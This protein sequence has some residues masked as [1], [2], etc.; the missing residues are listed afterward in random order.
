MASKYISWP[1]WWNLPLATLHR[2]TVLPSSFD[3]MAVFVGVKELGHLFRGW[4]REGC[5]V[6]IFN[7][8]LLWRKFVFT[9]VTLWSRTDTW[10]GSPSSFPQPAQGEGFFFR[11]EPLWSR[12]PVTH[13]WW[14][15]PEFCLL[16]SS[17]GAERP[18]SAPPNACRLSAL[19]VQ[20]R[21]TRKC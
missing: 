9:S 18:P 7:D 3:Q 4:G 20:S 14:Q 11:S 10:H 13:R 1:S 2:V 17:L 15:W 6:C 12:H 16:T 19:A 5:T 8:S 21:N